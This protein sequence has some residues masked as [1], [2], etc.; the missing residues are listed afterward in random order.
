LA[1]SHKANFL[2]IVAPARLNHLI[3]AADLFDE[4][5]VLGY[6]EWVSVTYEE[7]VELDMDRAYKLVE[8]WQHDQGTE[9]IISLVHLV[10]IDVGDVIIFNKGKL[11]PFWKKDVRII[12]DGNKYFMLDDY[13]R[14]LG[15]KVTTDEHRY[16][17]EIE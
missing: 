4:G 3:K 5:K 10:S 16:I 9:F 14:H 17:T 6:K 15:F 8:A 11:K 12:S 7:E 2:I 1:M 13:I